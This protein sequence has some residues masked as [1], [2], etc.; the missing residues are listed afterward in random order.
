MRSTNASSLMYIGIKGTVLAVDRRTGQ[1]QWRT[2]LKGGDFVNVVIDADAVYATA[3]G[4]L[5]CLDPLTGRVR[6]HNPLTG[7]GWG[8]ISMAGDS[9]IPMAQHYRIQQ[10][11][12]AASAGAAT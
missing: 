7:M 3:R 1:E 2:H 4:E 5:F 12:A 10:N 8:L 6:W 11:T 9:I